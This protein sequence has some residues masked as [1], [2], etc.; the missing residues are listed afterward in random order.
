LANKKKY[1][2]EKASEK[3]YE[4]HSEDPRLVAF[5]LPQFHPI[6]ENDK[7]WGRGFTEWTN[8]TTARSRFV[9]HQQ[10]I[11][12]ADLGFYDL[13]LAENIAS[14]VDLAKKHGIHGFCFY[15]YWFSGDR[16]LEKP[17]DI[18][19]K[20]KEWDFNF[21]IT[22]ANENW[23]KRWDGLE[24]DVIIAQKYLD[25]DPLSFIKDV[26][27]ILT[28]PRYIRQNGKPVLAVYRGSDLG[29]PAHYAQVWREYFQK[30]HGLDLHLVSVLNFDTYDP[31]RYGFDAGLEFAPLT[32]A[33]EK[34]FND[35]KPR[36]V[37]SYAKLL[38][39][40]FEGEISDYRQVALQKNRRQVFDFPVYR[41]VAPSWDN[42][43]RK[44]GKG[45][46]LYGSNPDLYADWLDSVIEAEQKEAVAPLVF[47][48]AWNEWAEGAIM[49]PTRH[50]GHAVLNR[51]S[52]V[53]SRHSLNQQNKVNFPYYGVTRRSNTKLAVVIHVFYEEEWRYIKRKLGMLGGV[54]YDLF[55]T[56]TEKNKDIAEK[57][58]AYNNGARV[59]VVPNRGRDVLPFIYLAH[60]LEV[61]GYEYVL[62]LHTKKS[63]HRTDGRAWF[64]G[65]IDNLLPSKRLVGQILQSLKSGTALVGP[66]GHYVSL[67]RY[68]GG[69]TEQLN[70][71][72][73]ALY[74]NK[75]ADEY[76]KNM[77]NYGFFA[78]T[79]F[80]CRIDAIKPL[81]DIRLI[82]EDFE[83]ERAQIDATMAHS[84][85]R[86]L[87]L[88]PALNRQT[89]CS[90]SSAG[91]KET[92]H[93]DI[94]EAYDFAP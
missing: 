86:L 60:R 34:N 87:S 42:E 32:A 54:D 63:T 10:P 37:S 51:T 94:K 82:P 38:D 28:D 56:V 7:A 20:H 68:I 5:Y 71:L 8:V 4:R 69:N 59:Y 89:I 80:W 74:G 16:L 45:F 39:I 11:L 13:R 70:N 55:V 14:Q 72:L 24:K 53:L 23:T 57:I 21:M 81:L 26:E 79:M 30:K 85:E 6:K 22:W 91:V 62:K 31:R 64:E 88:L 73:A 15:Y 92:T 77:A 44:K 65:M 12:P 43:A 83:P 76:L 36:F 19:L 67:Q 3:S 27:H 48:N 47:V 1:Y 25:S 66:K 90:S 75:K 2:Y 9:G 52:E 40:D 17:L 50:N 78:G 93:D 33:K 41:S 18:F 61:L 46:V 49:E 35:M 29:E 84:C 58:T